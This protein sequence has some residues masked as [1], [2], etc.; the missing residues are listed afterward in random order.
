MSAYRINK[1][2]GQMKNLSKVFQTALLT[3]LLLF[4]SSLYAEFRLEG[5][6]QVTDPYGKL[7]KKD[8]PL[9]FTITNDEN[10]FR[11]GSHE[12]KVAGQPEKYS[13]ALILQKNNLVWVQE[14]HRTPVKTFE[15]QIGDHKIKLYKEILNNPV[16][17]DY[18]LAIDDKE[19]FFNNPL[20]QINF[21]FNEEGIDGIS[22]DGMIA[23][24]GLNKA[25][26]ACSKEETGNNEEKEQANDDSEESKAC[27]PIEDKT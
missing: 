9:A 22:V 23:S 25:K 27:P 15:W 12:Y 18:I 21:E 8:M 24:L 16:K 7:I 5:L 6:L 2:N 20:A 4:C 17:G 13:I 11:I 14:F 1:W 26:D 19:Y 3:S 10:K